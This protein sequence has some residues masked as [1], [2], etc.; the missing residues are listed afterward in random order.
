MIATAEEQEC[1][2]EE[3]SSCTFSRE[4]ELRQLSQEAKDWEQL[5]ALLP[6]PH[7][8]MLTERLKLYL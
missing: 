6:L 7:H 8:L 4:K 3:A 1:Y 2:W 5:R